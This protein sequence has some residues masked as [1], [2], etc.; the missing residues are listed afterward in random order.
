MLHIVN[1][2]SYP[3]VIFTSASDG[4]KS[5]K[6]H[7]RVAMA[8]IPNK[9]K[10]RKWVNHINGNKWDCHVKNLEWVTPS[11]NVQHAVDTGLIKITK[12]RVGQYT[13]DGKLIKKFDSLKQ[14][15]G[16]TKAC[17]G[18]RKTANDKNYYDS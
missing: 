7:R 17:R 5:H 1:R 12:R 3:S 16:I 4:I 14:A 10:E 9:N 6:V 2:S 13:K 18:T 11:E 15:D 8:F